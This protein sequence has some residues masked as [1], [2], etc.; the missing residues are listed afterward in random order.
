MVRRLLLVTLALA[1]LVGCNPKIDPVEDEG[2]PVTVQVY[3]V[4]W[5]DYCKRQLDIVQEIHDEIQ[6]EYLGEMVEFE[7]LNVGDSIEVV[8]PLA[9]ERGYTFLIKT[10]SQPPPVLAYPVTRILLKGQDTP[11]ASW[12]GL[13]SKGSLYRAIIFTV[14]RL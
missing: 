11:V 8:A 4:S 12:V 14:N 1:L 13:I 7:G 2:K 9:R 3:W 6:G 10:G 5:C